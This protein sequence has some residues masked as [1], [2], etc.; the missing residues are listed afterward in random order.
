MFDA[1]GLK[2]SIENRAG[3]IKAPLLLTENRHF[4][5]PD[6]ASGQSTATAGDQNLNPPGPPINSK[7]VQLE[8]EQ[9]RGRILQAA[10]R[11]APNQT[12]LPDV[13]VDSPLILAGWYGEAPPPLVSLGDQAPKITQANALL[14]TRVDLQPSPVGNTVKISPAFAK[15]LNGQGGTIPNDINK[16]EW[17]QQFN[18]QDFQIGFALPSAIGKLRPTKVTLVTDFNAPQH[19]VTIRRGQCRGGKVELNPGGPVVETLNQPIG[20]RNVT[21]DVGPG[22]YDANGWVWLEFVVETPTIGTAK[23]EVNAM[24]MGYEGTVEGPPIKPVLPTREAMLP[25]EPPKPAP[26]K[27]PSPPK[28]PKPAAPKPANPKPTTKKASPDAKK[29][30]TKK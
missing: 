9:L 16:H 13:P 4:S 20:P 29:D 12:V 22:D 5:L 6:L 21:F 24:S 17:I 1:D 7:A 15:V 28:P 8:A 18:P 25:P 26:P 30:A 27:Q 2:L 3:L 19:T 10:M 14:R 23:W 11:P